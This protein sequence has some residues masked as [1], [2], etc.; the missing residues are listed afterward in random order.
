[1]GLAFRPPKGDHQRGTLPLHS[2]PRESI[3]AH[4]PPQRLED[5]IAT[6]DTWFLTEAIGG[7]SR[8]TVHRRFS[9]PKPQK[10]CLECV[11]DGRWGKTEGAW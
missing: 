9:L 3:L 5:K 1:M 7:L 8:L 6:G 2:A 11:R 10:L 4:F